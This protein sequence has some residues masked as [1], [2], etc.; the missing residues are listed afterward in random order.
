[1]L[2]SEAVSSEATSAI[3]YQRSERIGFAAHVMTEL[4]FADIEREIGF[5]DLMVIADDAALDQRPEAVDVLSVNRRLHIG[6][7]RGQ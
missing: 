1:M 5:A 2:F 7:W 4:K 6:L 3:R